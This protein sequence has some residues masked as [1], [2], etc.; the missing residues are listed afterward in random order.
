MTIPC[1]IKEKVESTMSEIKKNKYS[2][3]YN[4]AVVAKQQTKGRGR[5]KNIWV[6]Q[7]GNLFLSVRI[8]KKIRN[9]YHLT[10]YMVGIVVYNIIKNYIFNNLNLIIKWPN[11]IL[12]NNKKVAGIL[13]EFL[14]SGN[15]VNDII[16]G[17]GINLNHNPIAYKS[18]ATYLSK[19]CKL[20][21]KYR[22]LINE[23]LSEIDSW[24]KILNSNKKIIIKEWT[25][26][27]KKKNTNIKFYNN[28]QL[29]HGVYKGIDNNGAIKVFMNNKIN[30]FFNI[31]LT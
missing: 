26:R 1:F 22:Q 18:T 2:R 16:I 14:S 15:N 10:T 19:Y 23:L 4:V 8:K 20:K 5:R 17:I 11:D 25:S 12:I 24:S 28:N 21:I 13:I 9:N 30:N 31:E 7:K 29:H 6:S 27:S 3:Y